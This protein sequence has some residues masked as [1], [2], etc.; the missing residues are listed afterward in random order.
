MKGINPVLTEGMMQLDRLQ[1]LKKNVLFNLMTV[2][3]FKYLPFVPALMSLVRERGGN[4]NKY[5]LVW[6]L[7]FTDLAIEDQTEPPIRQQPCKTKLYV[8]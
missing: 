3:P 1:R 7:N 6:P 5:D 2:E 4:G 8:N